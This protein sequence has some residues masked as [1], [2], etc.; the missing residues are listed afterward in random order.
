MSK[1]SSWPVIAVVL[2][3]LGGG[4]AIAE[5]VWFAG[6]GSLPGS[7]STRWRSEAVL[8]NPTDA[9]QEVQLELRAR[10]L[11]TSA[12]STSLTLAA[13][14][15]RH[16]PD[17]YQALGA[18]PGSGVLR[19]DGAVLTW[20][21]TFNQGAT[22]TFG[23][24]VP[25]VRLADIVGTGQKRVFPASSSSNLQTGFRSNLLLLN[26]GGLAA[27]FTMRGCG[28]STSVEVA[29]GAYDQVNNL[30]SWL[31]CPNGVFILEVEAS[32]PWAGYVSTVD[33]V[34]GDPTTVRGQP[35][36]APSVPGNH[37]PVVGSFAA[38]PLE[39]VKGEDVDLRGTFAD[40]DGD[41]V[42]WSLR[43]DPGSTA[44]ASL[45]G[46]TSGTGSLVSRVHTTDAGLLLVEVTV[47]DGRGGVTTAVAGARVLCHC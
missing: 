27:T 5:E 9:A 14:E 37:P 4:L 25:P 13:G 28:G 26:M 46:P 44:K 39:L 36:P 41:P 20:V 32:A 33:P 11:A 10:G 29:G 42:S 40:P 24:D 30:G 18:G 34:T 16:L 31:G 21:R 12:A 23:Q 45:V 43:L 3:T 2:V 35:P 15:V 1:T 47:T 7:G 38:S 8:H 17:L 22:G 6:V 19:V